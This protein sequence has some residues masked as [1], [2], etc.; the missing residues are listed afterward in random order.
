[1]PTDKRAGTETEP[2]SSMCITVGK[3]MHDYLCPCASLRCSH[4]RCGLCIYHHRVAS[5]FI[6]AVKLFL[7]DRNMS[8]FSGFLLLHLCEHFTY[9]TDSHLSLFINLPLCSLA[10]PVHPQSNTIILQGLGK[11]LRHQALCLLPSLCKIKLLSNIGRLLGQVIRSM[12][13]RII[14]YS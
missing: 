14:R 2:S 13:I 11:P 12:T 5:A 9:C 1:M 6:T 7:C 3:E 4:H 8:C 10:L